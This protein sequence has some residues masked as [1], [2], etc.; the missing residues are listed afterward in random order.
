MKAT[1][2]LSGRAKERLSV[3]AD[4]LDRA[5]GAPESELGNK[6]DP[7]DEALYITLTLQTDL[8]RAALMWSHLKSAFP[9]WNALAAARVERI[10]NVLREGGLHRQKARAIKRLLAQVKKFTGEFSLR[11]LHEMSD[12]EA[13]RLLVSLTGFSWKTARC[14]L[15]YSLNRDTFPVDSNTFRIFKRVGVLPP[16]AVYRRRSLHDVL[17]DAIPPSERRA[18]HVNLV[19]HGQRTCLPQAPRCD[20]CVAR[21]CCAMRGV[22]SSSRPKHALHSALARAS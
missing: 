4:L 5:Y 14:V 13:E 10:A 15:L 8:P 3:L 21:P 7:L 9:N 20:E 19:V 16:S 12:P 18:F 1:L 11:R 6:T 17:Q 22:H 2:R